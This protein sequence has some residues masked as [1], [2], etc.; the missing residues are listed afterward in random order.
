MFSALFSY[1]Y[2][3]VYPQ[4][5]ASAG[6]GFL[7]QP[8]QGVPNQLSVFDLNTLQSGL[9]VVF[10]SWALNNASDPFGRAMG[11]V[12]TVYPAPGLASAPIANLVA[13]VLHNPPAGAEGPLWTG[14]TAARIADIG[15]FLAYTANCLDLINQTAAGQQLF[16]NINANNKVVLIAPGM[17]GGN[18]TRSSNVDGVNQMVGV[19]I[20]LAQGNATPRARLDAL[21]QR[22]YAHINGALN[23]H[24]QLAADMNATPLYSLFVQDNNFSPNFLNV[25]FRFRG[26][27]LTG[28]NLMNWLSPG[29]FN[30]FDT[31]VKTSAATV[32]GVLVRQFFMFALLNALY[33]AAAPGAG[34]D[35][36]IAFNVRNQDANVLAA[37]DF[38]PPAI[39]LAHELMHAMRYGAGTALGIDFASFTTT[40]AELQ[41]VGMVP[42]NAVPVSENAI[43]AQWNTVAAPDPSNVW[44][45]P[46]PRAGVRSTRR[47]RRPRP[48]RRCA[49]SGIASDPL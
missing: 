22:R 2:G 45:A 29:G 17:G 49:R 19:A 47:P 16:V 18:Q 48:P 11:G 39:G 36:D 8:G 1:I 5:P 23:R 31:F 38:R 41:F 34:A 35:S 33:P 26:Q 24:N 15:A 43:R 3:L 42:F 27:P 20:D 12:G 14:A 25:N 21:V 44:A 28:Q 46:R 40:L 30:V 37:P 13:Q 10:S 9:Y 4:P 32:Q 6:Y 7:W